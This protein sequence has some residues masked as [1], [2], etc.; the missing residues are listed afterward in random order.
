MLAR[1]DNPHVARLLGSSL[2]IASLG[3]ALFH[4]FPSLIAWAMLRFAL[5][6]V[7]G[8]I[9]TLA[10]FWINAAANPEKRGL[11]MGLY[12]TALYTG[13][14]TGPLLLVFLGTTGPIPYFATSAL[15]VLG[16]IPLLLAGRESPRI[17]EPVSGAVGRFILLVPT[18]T[19]GALAFG[20]VET[21][22]VTQ[23]PVHAVRLAFP[24]RDAALL[25]SA[26]T[27]GNI[28]FQVPLGLLSDRMDRRKLLLVLGV[29]SAALSLALPLGPP[30]FWRFAGL[31][32]L[33]GGAFG[34]IYTVA[35]AHLG[36]RFSGTDLASAN[37]AFVMLYS[38]GMMFGPVLIGFGMDHSSA[39]G[40]P[41]SLALM[42]ALYAALVATRLLRKP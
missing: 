41:M 11:V 34:A 36:A 12:A 10:E 28:L 23:L 16:L 3:M 7:I 8:I 29:L 18:A 35:L 9:F 15:L 17:D 38:V 21:G 26:F 24:E 19:F 20:A 14:A 2:A 1:A 22:I 25:L 42:M 5:G 27:F 32:F 31:L 40:L 37:A 39:L 30:E 13:F 33:L 6:C 4:V